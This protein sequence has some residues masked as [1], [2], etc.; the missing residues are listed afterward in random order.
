M[1]TGKLTCVKCG[2]TRASSSFYSN[3][4]D[5]IHPNFGVC[6]DCVKEHYDTKK[7]IEALH[8]ILRLLDVPFILE[9]WQFVMNSEKQDKLGD[10]LR[11]LNSLPNWKD[12][13]YKDSTKIDGE[14]IE[15]TEDLLMQTDVGFQDNVKFWGNK[16]Y[17]V[18]DY[19]FL[20]EVYGELCQDRKPNSFTTKNAYKNIARTQLQAQKALETANSGE[21]DKLMKTLSTLMGDANVKPTQTAGENS[22]MASWGEWVRRVEEQRPILAPS[23]EFEDVDGIE[24]YIKKYF[25]KHFSR[26]F[27]LDNS[28]VSEDLGKEFDLEALREEALAT[29]E[30]EEGA[31]LGN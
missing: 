20:N 18:D 11:Q 21:Y 23:A 16:R 6:K 9:R 28:P 22:G 8:D 17:S 29:Q 2:K 31:E 15:T 3:R 14:E 7:N 26:V 1:A 13:R 5:M 4:N 25:T 12:L 24:K 19:I 27:G 10:Y 30:E